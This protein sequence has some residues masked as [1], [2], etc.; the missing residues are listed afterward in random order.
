MEPQNHGIPVLN[1]LVFSDIGDYK[2]DTSI[3][4]TASRLIEG[5][6]YVKVFS[7]SYL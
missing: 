1:L 5:Q 4:L 7:K 6:G 2:T 3:V